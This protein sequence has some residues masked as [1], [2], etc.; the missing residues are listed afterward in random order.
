M[1]IMGY[2]YFNL[3]MRPN[4]FFRSLVSYLIFPLISISYVHRKTVRRTMAAEETLPA[5]LGSHPKEG[6]GKVHGVRQ[7][8]THPIHLATCH[9]IRV[10][11][12]SG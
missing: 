8:F 3:Q 12:V 4:G 6:L 7:A 10:S 5:Q 9:V 2:A 1:T 11:T